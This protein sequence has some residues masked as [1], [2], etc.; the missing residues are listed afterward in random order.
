MQFHAFKDGLQ[1]ETIT[2]VVRIRW[3]ES[4]RDHLVWRR[5]EEPARVGAASKANARRPGSSKQNLLVL[6]VLVVVQFLPNTLWCSND[7]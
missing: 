3:S 7:K 5:A 1:R 2:E 6:F 4:N